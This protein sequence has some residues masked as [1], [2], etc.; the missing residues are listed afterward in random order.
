MPYSPLLLTDFSCF[1]K[2]KCFRTDL[3]FRILFFSN[4]LGISFARPQPASQNV[5]KHTPLFSLF[6]DNPSLY[7]QSLPLLKKHNLMYLSDC[8]SGDKLTIMPYRDLILKNS[9]FRPSNTVTRWYKHIVEF[10]RSSPTSIRLKPKFISQLPSSIITTDDPPILPTI[11]VPTRVTPCSSWCATWDN[12]NNMPVFGRL[13][14]R[15]VHNVI[16]QHW[17]RVIP[18]TSTTHTPSSAP[19]M[20]IECSGC[21]LHESLAALPPICGR[22]HDPSLLSYPCLKALPHDEVVDLSS[23]QI[24]HQSYTRTD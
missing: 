10:T 11:D 7:N 23:Y 9:S 3:V 17:S 22:R 8:L 2:T 18:S 5:D 20:L 24:G 16:F 6:C 4:N 21:L 12:D 19:L 13:I 1:I 14:K 15:N